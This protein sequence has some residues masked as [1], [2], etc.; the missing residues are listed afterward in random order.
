MVRRSE[1]AVSSLV[2]TRV[3]QVTDSGLETLKPHERKIFAIHAASEEASP[4]I[5]LTLNVNCP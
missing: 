4:D 3:R 1:S 2:R 5:E